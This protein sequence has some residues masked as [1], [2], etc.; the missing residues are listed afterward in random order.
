MKKCLTD[1]LHSTGRHTRPLNK[2]LLVRELRNDRIGI[3]S[4][5]KEF[6]ENETRLLHCNK[7]E[8]DFMFLMSH[9]SFRLLS[10]MEKHWLHNN[11]NKKLC[12]IEFKNDPKIWI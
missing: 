6:Q 10:A 7:Q 8:W 12:V 1:P 9:F 2:D 11:H 5:Y 3:L 4:G